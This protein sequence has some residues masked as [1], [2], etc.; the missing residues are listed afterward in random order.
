MDDII[1]ISEKLED[2][3][4]IAKKLEFFL[5]IGMKISDKSVYTNNTEDI[6]EEI[7]IQ[8]VKIKK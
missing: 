6:T 4:T 2:F 3:T 7:I 1:I 8:D 5:Y